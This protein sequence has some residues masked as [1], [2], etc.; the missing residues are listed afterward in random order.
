MSNVKIGR[1]NI[2]TTYFLTKIIKKI[3][4]KTKL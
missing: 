3:K 1:A 4:Y 2:S